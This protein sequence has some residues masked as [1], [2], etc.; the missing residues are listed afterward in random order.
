MRRRFDT[1]V[2]VVG[3]GPVG[4]SLAMDLAWR[5]IS[6]I[7]AEQRHRGEAPSVKCNHVAARTMEMFRR[8]GVAAAVRD[9]GLPRDY[10]NDVAYRITTTGTELARILIPCRADRYTATGG[11]DTWWPTPE[12]P[13]RI[14]QIYLEPILF[15]HAEAMAGCTMLNRTR[16]VAFTQSE[17]SVLA[18]AEALDSGVTIEIRCEYLVGCEGGR[19]ETRRA[20]GAKLQG[21]AEIGRVQST[22]IRA[23]SL[24][25][26]LKAKPA[27]GTFSINER[28]SGN[29]YAIDGGT[30]WLVHNYLR[31]QERDFEAVDRDACL[32][33][34][35]GVGT[36]FDYEIIS[37]ED[38]IA[39]RLVADRFR[40]RRIF[41]CGDAAHLWVPMAGYGMNA[42]IADAMNLSWQLAAV[43]HGWAP[44]AILTAHEAERQPITEQVS[45]Y[46]MNHALALA[47]LHTEVPD[48][49]DDASPA[50]VAARAR[51]GR[52]LYDL[53]V[54]QYC[55]GG[56]NFGYFYDASP[57]IAYD[58]ASPPG[59]D[60]YNF[61]PSTVPGCRTPHLWLR[62]GRSLYDALGPVYTLIRTDP[63]AQADALLAAAARRRV[64]LTLLDLDVPDMAELYPSK[65]LLSRPD[66][67]VAW[68]GHSLPDDPLA[69]IDRIRGGK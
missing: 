45:R 43:L 40:D 53:N 22:F 35:L 5:G 32:R 39:R 36:D 69:L 65:F 49:I 68:R 34:I 55:C 24:L 58:D 52:E 21:D 3:G 62:D 1:H 4:L 63:S 20:I 17:T 26:R 9:A 11:P 10:P 50:G 16:V 56:L 57:I 61:T 23:P 13:H 25:R 42:G 37:K 27:W 12:P 6:V 7:V 60:M 59:Y 41:I 46:A 2:L 33:A 19:S 47:K 67:H 66:Q 29:V 31:A 30:T 8:L 64:P 44:Q 18:Q 15:A 54:Q 48:E 28:R 38:W 51:V 14:N